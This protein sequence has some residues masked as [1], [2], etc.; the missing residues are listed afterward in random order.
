[1]GFEPLSG[2]SPLEEKLT[3]E[4]IQAKITEFKTKIQSLLP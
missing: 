1:M 2:S 3:E 4:Q